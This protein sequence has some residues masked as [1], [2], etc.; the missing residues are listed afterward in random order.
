MGDRMSSPCRLCGTPLQATFVN[1]NHSPLANSLLDEAALDKMEP[2]YPLH[3][4]VCNECFLVQLPVFESPESIFGH[5]LYFSS[6]SETWLDHARRYC[7]AM[8]ERFGIDR[9]SLVVEVASNDGYLLQ[10][11]A[12][13]GIPVLGI[14]PAA[15]VA[16]AAQQRGIPTRV[17]FFGAAEA[18]SLR[19]SG[20]SADII[21]ANNVLAHVPNLHDF[22]EGFRILLKPDGVATF[23]FPHLLRLLEGNQ[24]DTIYHEHF[25]YLSLAVVERVLAE[26]GLLIF[27]VEE[28]PVHG[29]SLRVYACHREAARPMS[30]A[31]EAVRQHEMVTQ[32]DRLE[33]Y[34]NFAERVVDIKSEL[35]Q[36]LI[37]MRREGRR[38]AGYG[39][40]AKANT[41][42]NYCGIGRELLPFTVDCSP[43]KQG[44][45]LPGS[46]IPI[47]NPEAM[48]AA[49]PDFVLVLPWNLKDEI[50]GQLVEMRAWGATFVTAIPKLT[51]H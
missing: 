25:S 14:E 3:A 46:R 49:R 36:F 31:V 20:H 51:F 45:F 18:E 32:L 11:F 48:F 8:R 40:P 34:A 44:L 39:A 17:A 4:Y 43:H 16:A 22:V 19:S 35:L 37:D 33:T 27:D 1:L 23:E 21:C 38:V 5:Y 6:F 9:E 24:F 26:H 7:R 30:E 10:Y 41:L 42:L 2:H 47:L 12:E 28:L 29:G 13:A 15:N 50:V